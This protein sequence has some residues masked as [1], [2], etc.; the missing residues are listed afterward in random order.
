M[1]QLKERRNESLKVP[2]LNVTIQAV[3]FTATQGKNAAL[4]QALDCK[5]S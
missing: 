3:N 4:F 2:I 1:Q 5:G